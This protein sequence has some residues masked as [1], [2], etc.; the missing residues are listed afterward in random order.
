[1]VR[2]IERQLP[3][4][5][6]AVQAMFDTALSQAKQLIAQEQNSKNKLYSLHTPEVEAQS[7]PGRPYDGH[8]LAAQLQQVKK[9][10]AVEPEQCFIERG[11]RGHGIKDTKIFISGLKR[12]VTRSI[13]KA[14][15]RRSAVESEIGHIKNDG[16]LDNAI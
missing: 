7:C 15:K 12:G 2:D 11:Y 3:D 16:R 10:T 6:P 13:K 14:L 1:M 8:T 5:T 4:Y 9:L